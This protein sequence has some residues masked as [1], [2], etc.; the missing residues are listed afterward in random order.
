MKNK[1]AQVA[2]WI[3]LAILLVVSI[4]I[5][6]LLSRKPTL[7]S[8]ELLNPKAY[9]EKCTRQ[10]VND[11]LDPILE[12]GGFINPENYKLYETIKVSYLCK[13]S[14]NVH[15]CINQHPALLS[16][17][18][19][20]IENYIYPRIYQCF[21]Q[22]KNELVNRGREFEFGEINL[23]VDL[24]LGKVIVDVN[25]EMVITSGEETS[26]YNGVKVEVI[27]SIYD[28]ANVA[29]KI[30]NDERKYC[31]FEY[32]GYMI[33]Y[34]RFSIEKWVMS[35]NTKIYTISDKESKEKLNIAITSK[36]CETGGT[37]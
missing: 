34:P 24:I 33:L 19:K 21:L 12:H 14:E 1:K 26:K 27:S 15:G 18:D 23:S 4:I 28:L 16:E 31:Y 6:A 9:I 17:I 22:L 3:I 2:I 10:S 35:D 25:G 36:N 8:Q 5:F 13:N 37:I 11:A 20:E 30:L 29:V 32:V 7:T